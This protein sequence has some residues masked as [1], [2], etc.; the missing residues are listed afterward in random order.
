ME[1]ITVDATVDN[2]QQVVDFATERLEAHDCPMK[3]VIHLQLVIEEIFVNI[4]SYAYESG[5][6]SATMC[7]DFEE[8]PTAVS[9]TFIDSGYPYNPLERE[10][11]DTTLDIN[12]RDIGGLGIFLVKKNV[13]ELNYDYKDGQNIFS[14][15]KFF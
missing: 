1:R 4:A 3:A 2:L 10:D 5:T 15:K 11:P 14:I 7:I 8:N 6:G 13:D 12:E 9:L